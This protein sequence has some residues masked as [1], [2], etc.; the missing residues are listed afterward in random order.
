MTTPSSEKEV[1]HVVLKCP[2]IRYRVGDCIAV[3]AENDPTLVEKTMQALGL[4][5]Q[6]VRTALTK[7]KSIT[8]LNAKIADLFGPH[9][10]HELWD[11]AQK[12]PRTISAEELL[13]ALPPLLPRF[14]SIA[15]AQEVVGDE[16]HLTVA[17]ARWHA[18]GHERLGVGTHF[19][20]HLAQEAT[21]YHHPTKDFT[22]PQESSAPVIMIGPGTGVA[23]FRGFMQ[24][25]LHEGHGG[26]N[27]LF[28]GDQRRA[29]NFLY[30]PFWTDLLAQGRLQLSLAFSR[31]QEHKVYVQHRMEEEAAQLKEWLHQGAYLYVCGDA[32]RMAK[33]VDASLKAL[34]SPEFVKE[35]KKS[36]RYLRDVY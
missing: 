29:H 24:K 35:L 32:A 22:L 4:H 17:V 27:W 23:P 21:I 1:W 5:G 10:G 25:R 20:C 8:R 16:I 34:T 9:D 2:P 6:E 18:A 12:H 7:H 31:D 11:L 19:L 28:F 3:H 26:K 14:Y 13:A 36:G 30:E 15:S 33:D